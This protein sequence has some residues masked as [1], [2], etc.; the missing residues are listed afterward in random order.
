MARYDWPIES[1]K[2]PDRLIHR[3]ENALRENV[4]GLPDG[5]LGNLD[6]LD[7][8]ITANFDDDLTWLPVGP[9]ILTNGQAD[10]DPIVAGRVRDIKVSPD[11]QRVYV[12][13][14]NGGVWYSSNAGKKWTPIGSAG[15]DPSADRSDLTLTIGALFVEFGRN[16]AT[17]DPAKDI[18]YVGTGEP[19]PSVKAYPGGSMGGI[20]ILR[21]ADTL[22]NALT[23]Q[24]Q[25]PWKREAKNLSRA[26]VF[27]LARNPGHALTLA[28]DAHLVAATSKGLLS[29]SGAFSEDS[30]W[31]E[32]KFTP[33]DFETYPNA[34]C[35]DVVWNAQGLWV[36][37]VGAGAL[38]GVYLSADGA[39]NFRHIVL[40]QHDQGTRTSLG[41]VETAT[42]RMYVLGNGPSATDANAGHAH[43]WQIDVSPPLPD[44]IR[45]VQDFPVGLFV[46][47][48]ALSGVNLVLKGVNQSY[49]D[50]AIDVEHIAGKDV[51]TVGGSTEMKTGYNA[52]LFRLGIDDT[53]GVLSA[54][55][56]A[57]NQTKAA[58]DASFA[59]HGIHP[60]VHKITS[61]GPVLWVGCDGGIF[62]RD[63][64]GIP[65]RSTGIPAWEAA[66]QA[67][68]RPMNAG[69]PVAEPGY[70]NSHPILDGPLIAG[71]QDNGAI[72]RVGDTVW[73]LIN[74]GDGGG[75]LFHPTIPQQR[76]TQYVNAQ[77]NFEP[78][79]GDTRGPVIRRRTA[80]GNELLE[81]A[82][83]NFFSQAATA[84]GVP[85]A[86][87]PPLPAG[88]APNAR[89]FV[90]TDRIWYTAN[91]TNNNANPSWVTIPTMTDAYSLTAASPLLGQDQLTEGGNPEK[92]L[93]IEVL[94][95]GDIVSAAA[96]FVGTV[97]LVL[98]QRSVRLFRF[99]SP[100]GVLAPVW[101]PLGQSIISTNSGVDRPKHKK[102]GDDVPNPFVPYLPNPPGALWT[103]IAGH[104]GPAGQET[105]YVST[106][107]KV[108]E[109]SNG[110][111][112]ADPNYD[113]LWWYNG[114]GRWYPTGLRNAPLD[115][116]TG[117]GGS[118]VGA[119]SV[120]CDP[121]APDIVYVGNRI[122]VW[123]GVID[124]SGAH[125]SWTWAPAMEG[126]PQTMVQDLSVFKNSDGT[127][128]RAALVSRGVWERDISAVPASV[129]R[130]FIRTFA[131]DTGRSTLPETQRDPITDALLKFHE[132]PDIMVLRT[133]THPWAADM[134]NEAEMLAQ[135]STPNYAK[136][137]HD[138]FV[139]VHHRHII[140]VAGADMNV[141]VFLQ[142]AAP[143]GS[144]SDFAITPAW[145]TAIKEIV[146]GNSPAMPAGLSHLGRFNPTDP[147]E[148][149]TPG[150][151]RFSLDLNFAGSND[152]VMLIAVVT[153]P[154]NGLPTPDLDEAN[155]RDIVR[156]SAAIAVRKIHRT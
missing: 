118:P 135:P 137:M 89:L 109:N 99:A 126:L 152:H 53:A 154:G 120:V 81:D 23:N 34:Y 123:K 133:G 121:D 54:G 77:W 156:G 14:A 66:M 35:S 3:Q 92:V 46:S 130:T 147:V 115:P 2:S 127:Y 45:L 124:Q 79:T 98:C 50:Q 100:D 58:D 6:L 18:V 82:R 51:V 69:L 110:D 67:A 106:T 26:G 28:G 33:D 84:Q 70:I 29:R 113:T 21:L 9:T 32:I 43:L 117:T 153:S 7:D 75:C 56:V 86:A 114:Q 24:R 139:M 101:T 94:N 39:T 107:G 8:V 15:L 104:S 11:G 142:K 68:A 36:T 60:D 103:D 59:G 37:L 25:N 27:R 105:F 138:V 20:G 74:K 131:H 93:A 125:P 151:V 87:V 83:A 97:I 140:P 1:G 132:S 143:A 41:P 128:L 95:E 44:Q 155:L 134:P 31:Q 57:A 112:V 72:Q 80:A 111:L 4:S 49:Y 65:A 71:T 10:G 148:A 19:H 40:P 38:D 30:D 119:H 145:R 129:G 55:F 146:R 136:A 13:S 42:E 122:G 17:D 96:N 73:T 144:I 22:P 141:D 5:L 85:P 88:P 47:E 16:G 64:T 78:Y 12:A 52:A 102:T 108:T 76:V 116:A 61:K 90:G 48:V 91:W 149:R 62:R 150:V 63:T